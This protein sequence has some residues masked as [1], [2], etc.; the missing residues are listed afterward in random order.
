MDTDADQ[1]GD[2]L[3]VALREANEGVPGAIERFW[4]LRTERGRAERALNEEGHRYAR[5]MIAK[6]AESRAKGVG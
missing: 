6:L 1:A 4:Q 2:P 3:R 5:R